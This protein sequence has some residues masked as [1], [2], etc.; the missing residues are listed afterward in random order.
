MFPGLPLGARRRAF[1][2]FNFPESKSEFQEFAIRKVKQG[3]VVDGLSDYLAACSL[4][5]GMDSDLCGGN[6]ERDWGLNLGWLILQTWCR[7]PSLQ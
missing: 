3:R 2:S 6:P 4:I 5:V 7:F 1:L